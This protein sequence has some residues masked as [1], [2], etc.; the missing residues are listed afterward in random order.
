M[1]VAEDDNSLWRCFHLFIFNGWKFVL[2]KVETTRQTW[3]CSQ[4]CKKIRSL[5]SGANFKSV[6]SSLSPFFSS[7]FKGKSCWQGDETLSHGPLCRNKAF[8]KLPV[9]GNGGWGGGRNRDVP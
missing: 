3:D 1:G 5:G 7:S 2:R 9:G 4:R 6:S 8:K